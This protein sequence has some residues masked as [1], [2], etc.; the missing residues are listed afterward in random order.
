MNALCISETCTVILNK[1]ES[2]LFCK[3]NIK[4]KKKKLHLESSVHQCISEAADSR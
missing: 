4:K 1:K 3:D 2:K